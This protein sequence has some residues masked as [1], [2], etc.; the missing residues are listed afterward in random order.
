MG[1]LAAARRRTPAGLLLALTLLLP[2][3]LGGC[4][5]HGGAKVVSRE[6]PARKESSRPKPKPRPAGGYYRVRRGDT[7]YSIAWRF[8]ID[9]PSLAAWNGIRSPY[10]IYPGQRLRLSRPAASRKS[11]GSGSRA[12]RSSRRADSRKSRSSTASR[13]A[14]R[15][16]STQAGKSGTA[17]RRVQTGSQSAMARVK[18]NW[19]W[20]TSGK[21]VQ[22][23][24]A[25]DPG[26]KGIKI[27]GRSGQKVRAAEAGKVVYAGSGLIG[28]GRLIIIKH[29]KNY[30][31]AYGHN[32]KLLVREGDRVGRGQV[33]AEM[34]RNGSGQ[35]LLH[36]EIRRNGIPV[37]PLRLLPR[38]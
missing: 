32:R 13:P 24:S 14:I 35:S 26:K 12:A 21:V 28:Y 8:G 27:G 3:V 6:A 5:S 34:G 16:R 36:F 15:S 20:P 17:R 7:L 30:L 2:L 1:G 38:R 23:F 31:S 9:F 4:G 18:L 22:R 33:V 37:D 10:V 29:N 19:A 25:D 11:S